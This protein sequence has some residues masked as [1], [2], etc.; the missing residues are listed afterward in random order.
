MRDFT[1]W[2]ARLGFIEVVFIHFGLSGRLLVNAENVQ[3]NEPV[4]NVEVIVNGFAQLI[5]DSLVLRL[6]VKLFHLLPV[7]YNSNKWKII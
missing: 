4:L 1:P 6:C 2:G 5:S 7:N 3:L